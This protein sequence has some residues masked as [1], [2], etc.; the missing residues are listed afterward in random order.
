[1]SCQA[2]GQARPVPSALEWSRS[3]GTV[4]LWLHYL[5]E[6]TGT[7]RITERPASPALESQERGDIASTI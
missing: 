1:V 5:T 6:P 7:L 4:K 3:A 2:E